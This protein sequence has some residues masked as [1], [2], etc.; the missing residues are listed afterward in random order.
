MSTPTTY[1]Y[2][3][4]PPGLDIWSNFG[5]D[6]RKASHGSYKYFPVGNG[7]L[8]SDFSEITAYYLGSGI[9]IAIIFIALIL[10]TITCLCECC[11]LCCCKKS[12]ARK[13][14]K[15]KPSRNATIW[16]WVSFVLIQIIFLI[17][18]IAS[19]GASGYLSTTV[20]RASD[21]TIGTIRSARAVVQGLSPAVVNAFV[22]LQGVVNSTA[23]AALNVVDFT[24]LDVTN[25]VRQSM[26]SLADGMDTTQT[27]ITS[28]VTNGDAIGAS[29]TLTNTRL[30]EIKSIMTAVK[31]A[32]TGWA[33][34]ITYSGG[35]YTY[36]GNAFNNKAAQA[37]TA[38]DGSITALVNGVRS[39]DLGSYGTQI[40][41][42]ATTLQTTITSLLGSGTGA[43]KTSAVG[44]LRTA[45][46]TIV[47]SLDK[48][49]KSTED[50]FKSADSSATSTFDSARSY[51]Y[52][53]HIAMCLLSSIVLLILLVVNLGVY[54][55]RPRSSRGSCNLSSATFYVF[56]QLLAF[57]L[58]ITTL[59]IGDVC[60]VVF[61]YSP[62]P[63]ASGLDSNLRSTINNVFTFRDKCMENKSMITIAS[64]LNLIDAASVNMTKLAGDQLNGLDFTPIAS[65]WDISTSISLDPPLATKFAP[66]NALSPTINVTPLDNLL[67][68]G[69][70]PA[71]RQ[72]I[73]DARAE[74]VAAKN[75]DAQIAEIDR[76]LTATTGIYDL[77]VASVT[78]MRTSCLSLGTAIGNV[79]SSSA[80]VTARY[81]TATNALTA[82]AGTVTTS[83]TNFIPTVKVNV[84]S[85]VSGVERTLSGLDGVWF[86]Y[87][88]LGFFAFLSIP[89]FIYFANVMAA[90]IKKIGS[91]DLENGL[92][93]DMLNGGKP[94]RRR[95]R[96]RREAAQAGE[97]AQG[98][99]A[100]QG[101]KARKE[102]QVQDKKQP[103]LKTVEMK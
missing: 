33:S 41:G 57:I 55:K 40:R 10:T 22:S 31:N 38:A 21:G 77:T 37:E 80:T 35:T 64:E 54:F 1:K 25:G 11:C 73:D 67:A 85:T 68:A 84:V 12:L 69:G 23:D 15:R 58:F 102:G 30:T 42:V 34:S 90:G 39:I 8:Y 48:L 13:A 56:I 3:V 75:G 32:E 89:T 81:T 17:A 26:N 94:G 2:S 24:Q 60:G 4:P 65:S 46:T 29:K 95:S 91:V 88:V 5:R 79:Q 82:F 98:S 43:F 50:T 52:Y 71:L 53:R 100:A 61:D 87:Y 36:T 101:R 86:S 28:I 78:S 83:L 49:S 16:A 45:Q 62:P 63:I 20:S 70:L 6:I 97:A 27:A 19:F 47:D 44:A 96:P 92:S 72:L 14:L 9:V 66:I 74:L 76:I 59:V 7:V 93:G 99:Q 18:T 51:D 103:V